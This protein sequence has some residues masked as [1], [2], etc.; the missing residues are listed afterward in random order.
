MRPYS[1]ILSCMPPSDISHYKQPCLKVG[2]IAHSLILSSIQIIVHQ[3]TKR[4]TLWIKLLN[5]K[6]VP[7]SRQVHVDSEAVVC[8]YQSNPESADITYWFWIRLHHSKHLNQET[9]NAHLKRGKR[10]FVSVRENIEVFE[11]KHVLNLQ[12]GD[13][14]TKMNREKRKRFQ[15][16][17]AGQTVNVS[18]QRWPEQSMRRYLQIVNSPGL[19]LSG[20]VEGLEATTIHAAFRLCASSKTRDAVCNNVHVFTLLA[21]KNPFDW[22]LH[23]CKLRF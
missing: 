5:I 19:G 3:Q 6:L 14:C 17:L 21:I 18:V 7:E 20:S 9:F 2:Y 8:W 1:F 11:R 10:A 22:G 13:G 16:S 4:F 12:T 23:T 15:S